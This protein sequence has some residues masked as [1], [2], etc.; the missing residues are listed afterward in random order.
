MCFSDVGCMRIPK[1]SNQKEIYLLRHCLMAFCKTFRLFLCFIDS[2]SPCSSRNK[3]IGL[4]LATG[5]DNSALA[6]NRVANTVQ[7]QDVDKMFLYAWSTNQKL[8]CCPT[9]SVKYHPTK[10]SMGHVK[11]IL[12]TALDIAGSCKYSQNSHS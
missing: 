4:L 10:M 2:S 9:V 11:N 1:T 5:D 6:L 7:G 3:C 8:N 12:Y